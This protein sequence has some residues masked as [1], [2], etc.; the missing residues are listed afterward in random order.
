M[1]RA[2]VP[3]IDI[4]PYFSGDA[5]A[6]RRVGKAIGAACADIGFFSIAG[7]RVDPRDRRGVAPHLARVFRA[8]G[9][10]KTEMR[11]SRGRHAQGPARLRGGGARPRRR[12]G[13]AA[14]PQGVLSFRQGLLAGRALL[15]G[16][17][18]ETLLHPQYLARAPGRFPRRG[19]RL[20]RRHGRSGQ[21]PDAA[22]RACA[23]PRRGLVRGQDRP[24]RH[25]DADQP[26][27]AAAGGAA[28]GT[29]PR[30]RA[31][32]FRHVHHPDGRGRA[33]RAPGA[34]PRRDLVRRGNPTRGLRGQCGRPLPALD[35]DVWTSNF[36]RVVNPPAE[37][38]PSARRI[39]IGFF[40]Q[41]N[42]DAEIACLP[43]CTDVARPP[44]YRTVT[45]GAF[46]DIRYDETDIPDTQAAA[47]S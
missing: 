9:R 2:R 7:H 4:E 45:S 19:G 11:P 29:D 1:D 8:A 30:R 39:S 25:R 15:R 18:R 44:L 26:L 10:G 17:G 46:R 28:G 12:A 21:A 14:R 13:G 37:I 40:H 23:R 34:G 32:G 27:P 38:G 35:N 6:R 43:T 42:Y 47:I 31:Y 24:P 41:P 22:R 16:R 5:A 36:H 3:L 33:R 20:L